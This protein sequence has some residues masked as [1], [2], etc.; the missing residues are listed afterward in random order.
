MFYRNNFYVVSGGPGAGKTTLLNKLAQR[1]YLVIP[2][3]A[4]RI[5]SEQMQ[6]NGDALPWKNKTL[7][8][9]RMLNA[10][11]NSFREAALEEP[12][13][14]VLFDRGIPDALC[15]AVMSSIVV[16]P[17]MDDDAS[18]YRYNKNVF[19]LPPWKDIYH[20]DEERKQNWEEAVFT[21]HQMKETYAAYGYAII[22]I[23]H[24]TAEN[25]AEFVIQRLKYIANL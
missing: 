11:V 10:S 25:R 18:T 1:G 8:T 23:P 3:D 14:P 5:I 2:E 6:I 16:T 7:Y 13:K 9:W 20:T 17:E 19:L 22:E 12:V 21:F 24:D 15:Y 4:R